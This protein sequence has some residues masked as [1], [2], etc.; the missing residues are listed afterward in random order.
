MKNLDHKAAP[1]ADLT[2]HADISVILFNNSLCKRK[3]D[4]DAVFV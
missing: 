3:P 4:T 2:F 1:L